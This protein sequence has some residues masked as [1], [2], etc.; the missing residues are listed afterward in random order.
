MSFEAVI[1][2][3][4]A[5][6]AVRQASTVV[7][8]ST[9][10]VLAF[11]RLTAGKGRITVG[12]TNM[13]CWLDSAFEAEEAEGDILVPARELEAALSVLPAGSQASLVM[14]GSRLMLTSGR[15]KFD[16]PTLPAADW[17]QGA[18][19][20]RPV[21]VIVKAS[22]FVSS[23]EHLRLAISTNPSRYNLTGIYLD[24]QGNR[25]VA[26][27]GLIMGW[28]PGCWAF[29][30]DA[31]PKRITIP[32]EILNPLKKLFD[33]VEEC[34][35]LVDH[36]GARF[37]IRTDMQSLTS[38][39]V[40]GQFPAY[41]NVVPAKS[42]HTFRAEKQDLENALKCVGWIADGKSRP[43]TLDFADGELTLTAKSA[44]CG[45]SEDACAARAIVG[46]D[47]I[48]LA[49]EVSQMAWAISTLPV[50]EAADFIILDP[51][52]VVCVV[53]KGD[54]ERLHQRMLMPIRM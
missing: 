37:T 11:V 38:K 50:A 26:T 22:R 42:N 7:S 48:K 40:A 31:A 51:L 43:V 24:F 52:T 10:P 14:D 2:V 46:G 36:D 18:K 35:M 49:L 54:D 23:C 3:K 32:G 5:L 12:A 15:T 17:P 39:V 33:E 9:I 47:K 30:E 27:N 1:E 8:K 19:P 53:A 44:E 29:D 16:L 21:P 25:M 45:S 6:A 4:L 13:N 28:E 34:E 41:E 20:E